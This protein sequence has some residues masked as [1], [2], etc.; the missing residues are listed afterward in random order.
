VVRPS[1]FEIRQSIRLAAAFENERVGADMG[2]VNL[3]VP[4][5][6]FLAPDVGVD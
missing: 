6:G 2:G 3:V 4:R 1:A 5:D